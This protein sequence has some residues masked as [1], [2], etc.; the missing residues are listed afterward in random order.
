M[1]PKPDEKQVRE[2]FA[3]VGTSIQSATDA[4]RAYGRALAKQQV[5]DLFRL[6]KDTLDEED[7]EPCDCGEY[8]CEECRTRTEGE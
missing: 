5:A 2:A 6:K 4:L 3:K 8:K 1:I 7:D